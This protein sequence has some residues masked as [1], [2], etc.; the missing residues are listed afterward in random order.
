MASTNEGIAKAYLARNGVSAMDEVLAGFDLAKPVY[1]NPLEPGDRLL[2]F[3]RN[4]SHFGQSQAGNWFSLWSGSMPGVSIFGG[5]AGRTPHL[6]R[7]AHPL[8]VL[9]GTAKKLAVNWRLAIGGGNGGA[10]QI[11]VPPALLGHLEPLGPA[12]SS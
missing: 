12:G 9:E 2:Q 10:T 11:Y 8:R 4:P 6:Y 3:I 7:V 1:V 5:L